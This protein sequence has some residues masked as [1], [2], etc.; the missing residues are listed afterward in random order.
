MNRHRSDIEL[1]EAIDH[2]LRW[3]ADRFHGP[4]PASLVDRGRVTGRLSAGF[5]GIGI[6]LV[7]VLAVAVAALSGFRP[8]PA[9]QSGSGACNP[10]GGVS[11]GA[12]WVEFGGPDLWV[13]GDRDYVALGSLKLFLRLSQEIAPTESM[14]AYAKSPPSVDNARPGSLSALGRLIPLSRSQFEV[15]PPTELQGQLYFLVQGFPVAG[16]WQIHVDLGNEILDGPI[17][18]VG[19]RTPDPVGECEPT[20]VLNNVVSTSTWSLSGEVMGFAA[21]RPADVTVE[22]QGTATNSGFMY[23]SRLD[24]PK[25]NLD[26]TVQI[27]LPATASTFPIRLGAGCWSL[28]LEPGGANIVIA[29]GK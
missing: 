13:V 12:D 5:A 23:A 4:T 6:A 20:D 1:D 17:V 25:P 18:S 29:V 22:T 10:S 16:C 27:Q 15:P 2:L 14:T 8:A 11:R 9:N 24:P 19:E 3:N 28:S 26:A 7:G 21:S